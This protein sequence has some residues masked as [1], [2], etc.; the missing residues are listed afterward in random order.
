M[1]K[2]QYKYF[3]IEARELLEGLNQAVLDLE[4]GER[5]KDLV[6]RLLRLAHTLKGASRVV[7][8]PR[9]AEL[10]HS[11]EDV[12]TPYRD[13]HG[14]ISQACTNQALGMLDMIAARVASLDLPSAEQKGETQQPVAEEFFETVRV[15]IEEMDTLLDGVSEASVQITALRRGVAT[16][17]RAR[18]LAGN[19][20]ENVALQQR[21]EANG[22]G[23]N[24]TTAKARAVAEE[25]RNHLERLERDFATRID[26]VETE[27]AQ[28]RDA[29]YRLR[30]LP[31]ATVFAPL[32][33]A[34]RDAAQSLH[35]EV[36]FE[37]VGGT[38]RLDAQVLAALRDAL[39]HVV[40]NAVAHGI[41][42][43]VER[44]G[45]RM[46]FICTDDGRG[47]D[48]EDSSAGSRSPRPGSGFGCG[49]PRA[50]RSRPDHHEG[51]SYHHEHGRR[52]FRPGNRPGRRP[53]NGRAAQRRG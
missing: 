1:A 51:W 44:R 43:R 9:I 33:R 49:L 34:V 45:N 25:L 32:E 47:I 16:L 38:S 13:G 6:G 46:A 3:R 52:G 4:R 14:T 48:L 5:G 40:R 18:L 22:T 2:D 11:L 42:L 20:L 53:G 19:L 41:E 37:S 31:A 36:L 50:G 21:A 17:E 8:Q 10:A 26:Q 27:F 7:K 28:V 12:F 24:I 15:E 29:T 30:L 39:P 35:K 23:W